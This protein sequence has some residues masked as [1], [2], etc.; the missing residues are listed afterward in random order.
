[1]FYNLFTSNIQKR[2]ATVIVILT[3][4]VTIKIKSNLTKMKK[5]TMIFFLLSCFMAAIAGSGEKPGY[6]KDVMKAFELRMSGKVDEAKVQLE[7]VLAKDST[8]AMA[9]YEMARLN[10]YLL[11]G[12][13]GTSLDDV[14]V[15]INK[16][17]FYE[18]DNVIYAY[19]YAI[20]G[21]MNAY[22][23][24]EMGQE[25]KLKD[26]VIEACKRFEKVISL[27]PEYVEPMLY[28]VEIYGQLPPEMGGDSLK[29]V[30]YADKLENADVYFGAR[31]RLTLSL[32][33]T[34]QVTFW[35]DQIALNGR[36]PELLRQVGIAFLFKDNAEQA[37]KYF[38]EAMKAD[39]S[40][41]LLM[42]DLGRYHVMKVMQNKELA[43][44]ELP[45]AKECFEKYLNTKP[46]PIVPM[47]AYT[48]GLMA[49]TA[50]FSGNQD[51]GN[52]LMEE[53]NALD[54]YFSKASGAPG[55]LLFEPPDK[56]CHHYF[57]FFSPF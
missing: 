41:N 8:N 52:K 6:K 9:H 22:M 2:K 30:Y 40:Q 5:S 48:L 57:S 25:D 18:P 53:A 29:A 47:K 28:L 21:F 24:M 13:G 15:H 10:F 26:N 32:H 38:A 33:G 12:G 11:T 19:Y 31:A 27:K 23:G 45:L 1:V 3:I 36:T 42:L 16:A 7:Q 46:E 34:D 43:A 54:K 20:I 50:M 37:E 14:N 39:A 56:T 51:E 44:K 17:V 49:R 4:K 55:Q 35:E